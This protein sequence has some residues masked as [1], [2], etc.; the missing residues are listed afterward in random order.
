MQSP[1]PMSEPSES[2]LEALRAE[3]AHHHD[4]ARFRYLEALARRLPGQPVTVQRVLA[5]RLREAVVVYAGRA[6]GG[7]GEDARPQRSA[8]PTAG[9]ALAQLNRELNARAQA[10]A[11]TARGSEGA[12]LSDLKSVRQFR[13]VWSKISAEQQVAHSLHRGPEIAGPLNSHKLMLRSLSLMQSLSPDY[14]RCFL[15]QMDSL[16]WLEQASAKPA[17]STAKPVRKSRQKQ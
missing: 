16:L 7:V 3:G 13:K 15:S 11:D 9:A 8:A 10:D 2:T 1:P 17:S 4:P 6:R 14:L 5:G 12:S